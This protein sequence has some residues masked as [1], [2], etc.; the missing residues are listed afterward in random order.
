MPLVATVTTSGNRVHVGSGGLGDAATID[1]DQ[2]TVAD[3]GPR[4][5]RI[6]ILH[7]VADFSN[8]HNMNVT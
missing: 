1:H 3:P 2:S 7:A 6:K 5:P 4:S 8:L